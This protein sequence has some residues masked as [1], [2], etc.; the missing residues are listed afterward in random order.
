MDA[1]ST[2]QI[3]DRKTACWPP[4]GLLR[5]A[6][7][8]IA[9]CA[10]LTSVGCGITKSRLAS[11]QLVVAD[12]VD[13]AVAQIDFSPLSGQRVYL[14]TTHIQGLKMTPNG[15]V[16]YVIGS[17]RQQMTAYNVLLVDKK[18]EAQYIAEARLGAMANDNNEVT[19]GIPGSSAAAKTAAAISPI[20]AVASLLPEL[21]LGRRTHQL[22][23][24]KIGVFA[25][26]R[27]TR[28]PVWQAGIAS[29]TSEARDLWVLGI[30]PF[31][32]GR[33]YKRMKADS[34]ARAISEVDDGITPELRSYSQPL[35][36]QR[37]TQKGEDLPPIVA[38]DTPPK[39]T[40]GETKNPVAGK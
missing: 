11:E 34:L 29:G 31:Q 12:A 37:A 26:D 38:A 27:E 13:E 7:L 24:A 14:D 20:G 22:A 16:E 25:Y 4:A 36:F 32:K 15:N 19:Y 6:A 3:A 33:I 21:S 30:G 5:L 1:F 28:E 8:A 23:A 10:S 39:E 9:V 40:G 17:L 2:L 35:V 18:E